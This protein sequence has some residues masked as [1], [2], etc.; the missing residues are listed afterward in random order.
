MG[1]I[2]HILEC[3]D[4]MLNLVLNSMVI[5][6]TN[7]LGLSHGY[8]DAFLDFIKGHA[9]RARYLFQGWLGRLR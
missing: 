1:H 3:I 4:H 5:T 2:L 7:L 9:A 8:S 6:A